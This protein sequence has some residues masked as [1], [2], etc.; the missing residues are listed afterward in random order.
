M[1]RTLLILSLALMGINI[2]SQ[3][4]ISVRIANIEDDLEEYLA[5]ANQTKTPGNM[6][7]GSSDLELGME[8]AGNM[9]PQYIG[10]RFLNIAIPAGSLI[11]KAYLQFTV[12]NTNKN[13]DPCNLSIHAERSLNAAAFNSAEA[14]NLSKRPTFGDSVL[15]NIRS[16]SWATI[17][18]KSTDQRSVDISKL[19][20]EIVNQNGWN[21][22]NAA[23]IFIKGS[24]LREAE[25]FD[26]SAP[27]APLLYIEFIPVQTFSQRI[28]TAEDDIEEYLPGA[29]QTKTPGSMDLGSSDLELGMESAG[30][31][32]PQYVGMRFNG[33]Q[34]PKGSLIQSAYLQFTVDNTNKNTD[35]SNLSIWAENSPNAA[36]FNS[37]D[38]FNLTKRPVFS[39]SVVWNIPDGSWKTIGEKGL[40]QQSSNIAQLIQNIVNQDSWAANNSLALFIKGNSL[41]EAESYD[42]SAADAPLLV[43]QY[44]ALGNY[45]TSIQSVEDDLE[46]Y[47]PGPNQTKTPGS[48]DVGSSDLELGMESAGNMDPQYVGMRFANVQLPKGTLVKNAYLQFTVD[49]TNKN[50]DPSN[51]TIW[52]EN[53]GNAAAFNAAVMFN[54]SSRPVF[55]DSITWN[56]PDGSWKTIGEKG[57][58][59]RSANIAGLL[60]SIFAQDDWTSGNALSLFIK[61]NGL[62]EAESYDGS[63][64]DAPK[65]LIEYFQSSKPTL[66]VTPYPVKRKSEWAYYDKAVSPMGDWTNITFDDLSWDFGAA[67]LGFGDPFI[68][69][70]LSFGPDPNNKYNTAYFRKKIEI[71]DTASLGN[72]VEFNLRVDDGA[73][74]YVNGIEVFRT[75]MPSGSVDYN[76]KAVNRITGHDESYYYVFDVP[77]SVFQNGIN[78]IAAE[79]HQWG[80]IT[81]DLSFDL[82]INNSLY[83]SNPTDLGCTDPN[84]KHIACFTSLL[85]RSQDQLV[86]VPA[87][88]TFQVLFGAF[89]SY[90]G[91]TGSFSTNFDF[92][93]YVP[94]NGS[95]TLGYLS[96]NHETVPGGVSIADIRYDLTS[97]LWQVDASGPVDFSPVVS[98]ATNCSGTVTPWN[99]VITC[100]EIYSPTNQD[101]NADGYVDWGWNVE[102]DPV[103]RMVKDYG[104]GKAKLWAMGRMSH[105]NLVV[106]NDK[107]TAYQGEDASDGSVYKFIADKE[108]DLSSGKLYVLKLNQGMS[109]G[110]PVSPLGE[111]LLVPNTTKDEQ[112]NVKT[113]AIQNGATVFPGVEDVEISPLDGKVYFAVKGAGRVYRFKDDGNTVSAFETFAGNRS[114]RMNSNGRMVSEPWAQGNDNLTFDDRGNLWVLQDGGNNYVWVIRPDH[115]QAA[116]KVEI[117]M[118]S[119]FGSEP[120]GMTFTPDYKYMFI[121]I[122]EPAPSNQLTQKD[123]TGRNIQFNR[124]TTLVVARKDFLGNP[125]GTKETKESKFK[126]EIAPNPFKKTANLK[127][128]FIESAVFSYEIMDFQGRTIVSSNLEKL[129]SGSHKFKIEI[130]E[131]GTYL[132][133]VSVNGQIESRVIRTF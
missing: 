34:I 57:N 52:A 19:I 97:K 86:E 129:D 111:W 29:N 109:G 80:P 63:A 56:I 99:T 116:P 64:P 104:N 5:G 36:A 102:I 94:V 33:I 92:T 11:T 35:P 15:W 110:E 112:N 40:D 42:G 20:Q 59:Q 67:P 101:A 39:D 121:S 127:I 70:K 130:A 62:K 84:D 133:K 131:P 38:P 82:E 118:Q 12:D 103:T 43:I 91:T 96:V 105:E 51:L 81:S 117:F 100:E 49:N 21:S 83:N 44:I 87:S 78:Q 73:I 115:T 106:L 26:G 120:T 93:G 65:L 18:E 89:D 25:S 72:Q 128:Q 6:D 8:S 60:N 7:L 1:Q 77:K 98:T 108:S 48:M 22:G 23:A 119:P 68:V 114:Y 24:G 13:T 45:S 61:G 9:D 107:R 74:V 95:S 85:A 79:V 126:L 66:A 2:F 30:N 27:D 54:L 10:L 53:T 88:H 122:Q 123:A 28:N 37:A 69:T 90:K 132:L 50:T 71:T 16:G 3:Q 125:T 41:K 55:A 14:F 75:N 4:S 76:T 46:E 58:D 124:S 17:G 47:L 32:D 113:W 31:M